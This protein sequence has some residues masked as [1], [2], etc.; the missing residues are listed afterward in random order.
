MSTE[1]NAIILAV[2]ICFVAVAL[3]SFSVFMLVSRAKAE[4]RKLY[5]AAE[6]IVGE[7]LLDWS[8]RNPYIME[9]GASAPSA[10]RLMIALQAVSEKNKQQS[11]FDVQRP[12]Y[13]GRG[14]QCQIILYD[15]RISERH[16]CIFC[17]KGKIWIRNLTGRSVIQLRQGLFSRRV[18]RPGKTYMLHDGDCIQMNQSV[19]KVRL[20]V[21]GRDHR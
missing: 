8:I 2:V 9:R 12:I 11:V 1:N 7:E 10:R 16:A 18:V 14:N 6:K 15:A 20:F 5:R 19:L 21:Y 4:S 13:I 3:G 17:K